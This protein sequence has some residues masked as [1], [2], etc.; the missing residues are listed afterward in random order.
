MPGSPGEPRAPGR[1]MFSIIFVVI[2]VSLHDTETLSRQFLGF[3]VLLGAALASADTFAARLMRRDG[4]LRKRVHR[5][6][7]IGQPTGYWGRIDLPMPRRAA[8]PA[9]PRRAHALVS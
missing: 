7:E 3:L 9:M 2:S 4:R 8:F 6:R 1:L 5:V